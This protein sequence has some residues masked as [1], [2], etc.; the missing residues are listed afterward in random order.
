MGRKPR[1]EYA[2]AL[3]H[4]M[5]RGNRREEIFQCDGDRDAFLRTLGEVCERT[6]WRICAY[7]LMPNHYHMV[8]ETPEANLVAGMK[9][10]QGTYTKRHNARNRKWGH[11]FQ[12][13]YKSI[14]IDSGDRCYFRTAC[15]YVHLNPVRAHLAGTEGK[16]DLRDFAWSSSC[17]LSASPQK[18]PDW[19]DI[20]RV[21]EEHAGRRDG[22]GTRKAYLQYLEL[23]AL[24]ECIADGK[25][26][27][28]KE[29]AYRQL[30]RGWYMG[31]TGFRDELQDRIDAQLS[32]L[33]RDSITGE[34]RRLHDERE[35]ER[36]LSEAASIV[37]LDLGGE[38]LLKKSDE[39]K[40]VVA[41]FLRKKTTM[42]LDWIA[43]QLGMG[44]RANV[45]RA[46]QSVELSKKAA[47]MHWV[48]EMD[49]MY[50]CVH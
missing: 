44:S 17:Y 1:V 31:T 29:E 42:G 24:D 12:G 39:R 32:G 7:V 26:G 13:R 28:G 23:R 3:Y 19:L 27:A 40:Q 5:C 46:V 16:P 8:L 37:G 49:K 20:G 47:V 38:E 14:V 48:R 35:A 10:F 11:V 34:A 45:G 41:W 2:G 43:E 50:G 22:R 36:L 4:V 15:D 25:D 18:T 33:R 30:R 9:W 6:G 21:V